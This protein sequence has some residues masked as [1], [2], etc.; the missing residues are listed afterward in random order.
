MNTITVTPAVASALAVV[1]MS[2][3]SFLRTALNIKPT[4]LETEG[5]IFPEGTAFMVWYKDRPHWGHV[6]NGVIEIGGDSFPSV[7]AAAFKITGRPT[8][9]WDFWQCKLPHSAEFVRISTLRT[10]VTRRQH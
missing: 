7:S 4:G 9:G 1:G 2:A 5:V 8:N 6:R 3:D 10:K